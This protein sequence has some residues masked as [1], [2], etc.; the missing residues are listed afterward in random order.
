M[1]LRCRDLYD[2]TKRHPA[3]I[4]PPGSGRNL[5][6][7]TTLYRTFYPPPLTILPPPILLFPSVSFLG[8]QGDACH[9]RVMCGDGSRGPCFL[10]FFS[11]LLVTTIMTK[12][13]F[14]SSSTK[15][16]CRIGVGEGMCWTCCFPVTTLRGKLKKG[17]SSKDTSQRPQTMDDFR[18]MFSLPVSLPLSRT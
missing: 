17:S 4:S 8:T 15:G 2:W 12:S 18:P 5:L 7:L 13:N 3:I 10:F 16:V 6:M 1:K 11:F 14:F 9:R